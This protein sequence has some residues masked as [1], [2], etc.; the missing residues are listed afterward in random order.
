MAESQIS[1]RELARLRR[2][3]K[4]VAP[5][6]RRDLDRQLR[7]IGRSVA[8]VADS[9]SVRR[10]GKFAKQWK[11]SLTVGRGVS[12]RNAAPQAG[13]QEY[14]RQIWLRRGIPYPLAPGHAGPASTEGS[15][16]TLPLRQVRIDS[17][18]VVNEAR[19]LIKRSNP[20]G[21]AVRDE[22]PRSRERVAAAARAAAERALS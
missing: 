9:N 3:I 11:V 6:V 19:Y 12:V 2:D 18:H 7:I 8:R 15:S 13:Q 14:G 22:I 4:D 20:G 5:E 10:T 16:G 17:T 21:R 1:V